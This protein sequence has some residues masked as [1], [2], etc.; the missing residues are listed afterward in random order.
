ML[1]IN[2]QK[3]VSLI[4]LLVVMAIVIILTIMA[5]PLF[6]SFMN[7]FRLKA[8]VQKLYYSLQYARSEAVKQNQAVYVSFQTSDNWCYGTNPAS[9]CTCS[10]PSGCSLGATTAPRTQNLTLT[11]T[12]LTSNTLQFEGSRGAAGA[13]SVITFTV[14]GQT[15]TMSIKITGLGNMI[16]CSPNVSGYPACT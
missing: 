13:S 4:E 10:T 14:Y 1:G 2:Q 3:G 7:E 16:I 15:P 5:V 8:T 11:V 6:T 9:A 12:G